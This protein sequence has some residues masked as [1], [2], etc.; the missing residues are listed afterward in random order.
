MQTSSDSEPEELV[1]EQFNDSS[2]EDDD[3]IRFSNGYNNV[4]HDAWT[5]EEVCRLEYFNFPICS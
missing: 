2:S 5:S 3:P 4:A 1:R